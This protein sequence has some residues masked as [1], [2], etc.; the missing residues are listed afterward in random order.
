MRSATRR[1]RASQE[2]V[3]Q[4]R[5]PLVYPRATNVQRLALVDPTIGVPDT[6]DTYF[7]DTF[8]TRSR[9]RP[10]GRL[11]KPVLESR[12]AL[13]G[14]LA[15]LDYHRAGPNHWYIDF[16][17][18]RHDQRGRGYAKRLIAAFYRQHANASSIH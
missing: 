10:F 15:F 11:K 2:I 6:R 9:K 13:P 14:T 12:G 4:G 3:E 16:L 5:S 7:V 18:S 8:R 1:T 17:K